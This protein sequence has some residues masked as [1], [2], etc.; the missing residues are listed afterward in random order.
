MA[1][2]SSDAW[3]VGED[4]DKTLVQHWDGAGWSTVPSPNGNDS[5][6]SLNSLNA[7]ARV[8]GTRTLWAVGSF[9]DDDQT[10]RPLILQATN[11]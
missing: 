6:Y 11:A 9:N 3:I 7:V 10:T 4:A 2:S 1:L 5:P 8:P